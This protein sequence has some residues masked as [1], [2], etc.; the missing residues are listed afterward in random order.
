M[1]GLSCVAK[2]DFF[3]K[4]A[5]FKSFVILGRCH[6][7]Y[8]SRIHYHNSSGIWTRSYLEDAGGAVPVSGV[9]VLAGRH[10]LTD[11]LVPR[12]KGKLYHQHCGGGGI[13][14]AALGR[15]VGRMRVGGG[16]FEDWVPASPQFQYLSNHLG[17]EG[18]CASIRLGIA[19]LSLLC[20]QLAPL[21]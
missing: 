6:I 1:N 14:A 11:Q 17:G 7:C 8:R 16:W 13:V 9:E 12:E 10:L 5:K 15:A 3:W 2:K 21:H 4:R 18:R 20:C 19:S